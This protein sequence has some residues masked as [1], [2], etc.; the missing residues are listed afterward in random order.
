MPQH[1]EQSPALSL[2]KIGL[3]VERLEDLLVEFTYCF[4]DTD[5]RVE[6][7]ALLGLKAEIDRDW[8]S[9][10]IVNDDPNLPSERKHG[11]Q[12]E[13]WDAT[14]WSTVILALNPLLFGKL[15]NLSKKLNSAYKQL[16]NGK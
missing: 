5:R 10:T 6:I 8:G 12:L 13:T 15:T 1:I 2:E 9:L 14:A 11:C 4:A 7:L 16:R 3:I